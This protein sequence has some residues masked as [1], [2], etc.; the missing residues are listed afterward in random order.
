MVPT[1]F[2]P[3]GGPHGSAVPQHGLNGQWWCTRI[4]WTFG[5]FRIHDFLDP[6]LKEPMQV[7]TH[8]PI[9][10]QTITRNPMKKS[11]QWYTYMPALYSTFCVI[12]LAVSPHSFP[13]P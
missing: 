1:K 8:K 5:L 4:D 13:F 6:T 7:S 12:T 10:L 11:E 3:Q 9:I 2:K